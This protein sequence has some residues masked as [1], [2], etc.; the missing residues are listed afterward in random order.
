MLFLILGLPQTMPH[1]ILL[2]GSLLTADQPDLIVPWW[3]FTKTILAV[4][5]L[6]LVR[7]GLIGLDDP[8]VEGP[9][10]LRQLLQ[11]Q[12]GL[13]DYSELADYPV[14]VSKGQPPWLADDMLQRLDASRL[15]Y[16][17]GAGWRYSNVGYLFVGRVIERLTGSTLEQA[18]ASRIFLPLGVSQV[19]LAHTRADLQGVNFGAANTYHPGWVYHGLLVGPLVE[20]AHVLDRLLAGTLLPPYLLQ[21]M[22]EAIVLGGPMPGR[23]WMSPGY[24]LGLMIGAADTGLTLSGHTGVGP[25]GIIAVFSASHGDATA[26]CAVFSE[27]DDE[28]RV[29]TQVSTRLLAAVGHKD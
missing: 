18:L 22:Q 29:E 28:G 12:A 16:V 25:G 24:G 5:A 9:F 8:L 20:A 14:A 17:P 19:R 2:N 23:P 13:A 27:T 11:H 7:D 26:T 21:Q 6:S 10:T 1:I 4:A 3:S 15:R